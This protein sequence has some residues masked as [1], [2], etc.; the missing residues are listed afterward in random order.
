MLPEKIGGKFE[1]LVHGEHPKPVS[2]GSMVAT[3][4]LDMPTDWR[5]RADILLHAGNTPK[6]VIRVMMLEEKDKGKHIGDVHKLHQKV[7]NR[8][9]T[10]WQQKSG[11]SSFY[12][13]T[14][15]E[16]TMY[17]KNC[18]IRNVSGFNNLGPDDMFVLDHQKTRDSKGVLTE[19]IGLLTCKVRL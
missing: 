11:G 14:L 16:L 13:E 19:V 18:T 7:Q 15:E 12:L 2:D 3:E 4:T 8:S 9:A 17:Y 6:D 5:N 1:L 10:I